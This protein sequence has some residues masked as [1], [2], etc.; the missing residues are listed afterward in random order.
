[1]LLADGAAYLSRAE[2][3]VPV[4]LLRVLRD[5]GEGGGMMQETIFVCGKGCGKS[6]ETMKRMN[7][8]PEEYQ[9]CVKNFDTMLEDAK[10][11]SEQQKQ[12]QWVLWYLYYREEGLFY[13]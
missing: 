3:A 12:L 2:R 13:K 9:K 1:M 4:G 10:R 6:Y 5:V 11:R 7:L 8:T